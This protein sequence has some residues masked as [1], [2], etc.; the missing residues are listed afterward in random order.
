MGELI[1]L[2]WTGAEKHPKPIELPL[3]K[4][5]NNRLLIMRAMSNGKVKIEGESNAEDVQFL[6]RALSSETR[7]IYMGDGGTAI[8]FGLAWAAITPGTRSISGSERLMERPISDLI[9]DL[10]RI[11][12]DIQYSAK[13]GF[14]PLVVRGKELRGGE[15]SPGGKTSSQFISALLLI[16]PYCREGITLNLSA[17]QVSTP[18][19]SMTV[20][21]MKLAGA[22]ISESK[23]QIRVAPGSYKAS[24]IAVEPDWSGASYFYAWQALGKLPKVELSGLSDQSIQGDRDGLRSFRDFGVRE[25]F[26]DSGLVLKSGN[27]NLPSEINFMESPDLAQTYAVCAAGLKHPLKLTGLQTLRVKET[28]RIAALEAELKKCGVTCKSG[29]DFIELTGFER[30]ES[31]PRIKTYRDHRMAMAFAPL[32]AR[33]GEIEIENPDVVA[34]S[35]PN[36]WDE[37]VKLGV[38]ITRNLS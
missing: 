8:R 32:A 37:V 26:D 6:K 34:K 18:Y 11:G 27:R 20:A 24:T 10:R 12:A 21:L 5:I 36:Y 22:E 16:A 31:V 17:N 38:E 2:K 25:E 13:D 33:F 30:L 9:D 29:D 4:S 15:I 28:D 3:S 19:I 14:A 7:E 35:F 23:N 1:R